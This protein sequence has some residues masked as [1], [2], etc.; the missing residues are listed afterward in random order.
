MDV[1]FFLSSY[2]R[3]T[4]P[5]DFMITFYR[6]ISTESSNLG[7]FIARLTGTNVFADIGLVGTIFLEV[8]IILRLRKRRSTK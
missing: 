6:E 2:S 8:P 4:S 3:A 1:G 5:H 7:D